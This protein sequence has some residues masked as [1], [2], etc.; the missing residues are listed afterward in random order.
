M[1]LLFPIAAAGAVVVGIALLLRSARRFE[2]RKIE[3]GEWDQ[4]GP[5]EP[6]APPRNFYATPL[7][8]I[9]PLE[10][11]GELTTDEGE[12]NGELE[13]RDSSENDAPDPPPR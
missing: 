9:G 3:A 13:A 5:L 2:R 1:T 6:S 7:T 10:V 11:M 8:G 12:A 4:A